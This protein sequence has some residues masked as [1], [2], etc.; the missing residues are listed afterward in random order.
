MLRQIKTTKMLEH[1]K[2]IKSQNA[3]PDKNNQKTK[4]DLWDIILQLGV[5]K[6]LILKIKL[7]LFKLISL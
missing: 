1:I 7:I 6:H 2:T 3:S 5:A 4:H